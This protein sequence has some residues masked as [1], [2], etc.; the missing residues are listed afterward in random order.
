MDCE[1]GLPLGAIR[2]V[3]PRCG[4]AESDDLEVLNQDEMHRLR[5]TA[6]SH[7][8]HLTVA[9]CLCCGEE[10]TVT[11]AGVPTPGQIT[12][13]VCVHCGCRLMDDGDKTRSMDNPP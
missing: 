12:N 1:D 10:N 7:W 4:A 13:A 6:C 2:I 9:E 5:C 3:C 8:F 11:W